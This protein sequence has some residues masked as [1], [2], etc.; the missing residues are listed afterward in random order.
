MYILEAL[1]DPMDMTPRRCER[2]VL[3]N[4]AQWCASTPIRTRGWM[5]GI[6]SLLDAARRQLLRFG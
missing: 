3:S 4:E 2:T 5:A 1:S 6:F